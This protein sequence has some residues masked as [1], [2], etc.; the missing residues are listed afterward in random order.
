MVLNH[1]KIKE[2][3]DIIVET[4]HNIKL[5][6]IYSLDYIVPVLN[7]WR[8]SVRHIVELLCEQVNEEEFNKAINHI[9]RARFD[10][11]DILL[12]VMFEVIE[13]IEEEYTYYEDC[14]AKYIPDYVNKKI[15]M[16][17]IKRISRAAVRSEDRETYYE[18]IKSAISEIDDY[19]VKLNATRKTWLSEIAKK[20]RIFALECIGVL[21]ATATIVFEIMKYVIG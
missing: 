14:V 17:E 3:R 9:K 6:E 2:I 8:Y 20:K 16:E 10:S 1:E 15:R 21:I 13:N 18:V 5:I 11:Y 4:E 19:I 12:L 7:E